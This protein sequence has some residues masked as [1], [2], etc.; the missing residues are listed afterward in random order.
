MDTGK[1]VTYVTERCVFRLGRGRLVLT[2]VAPGVD[3]E[4]DIL[5][6][7][8]FTP[9]VDGPT[10]MDERLFTDGAFGL[11]TRMLDLHIGQ[12]L[13]YDPTT[14]TAFLD[15]GG[16][17]VRS[18]DDVAHIVEAVDGL[19]GPIGRRVKAVVNYD[20]FQLDEPAVDAYADAVRYVQDTYY[21]ED[22]ARR[23]SGNAFLRLKLSR[24]L[25]KRDVDGAVE[26][27]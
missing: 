7:L 16:L 10:L 8:P 21:V 5:S 25:D 23:Y 15:F 22:G 19:L 20:R 1:R 3:A 26:A 6:L 24:E 27:S 9:D 2:E 11:R 4:R 17:H 12:R 13:S 18:A 14:N